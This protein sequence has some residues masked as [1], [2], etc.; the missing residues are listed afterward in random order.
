MYKNKKNKYSIIFETLPNNA[1]FDGTLTLEQ[2][3]TNSTLFDSKKFQIIGKIIRVNSYGLSSSCVRN[4]N[5]KNFCY[6][7][8]YHARVLRNYNPS[9]DRYSFFKRKKYKNRFL[10]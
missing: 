2:D 4:Y 10:N 7:K 9:F 6:C 1:T 3:L 8:T 5:L